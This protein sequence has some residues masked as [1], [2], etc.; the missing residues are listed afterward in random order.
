MRKKILIACSILVL[1]ISAISIL[2]RAYDLSSDF[3]YASAKLDIKN[4]NAKV[5]HVG[6]HEVS[7][8]EKEIEMIAARYGFKNIYVE[9][10]TPKQTEN[11]IKNYNELIDTYL[12]FRN[13]P[14]WKD[15]YK[16]EIDSVLTHPGL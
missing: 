12:A 5:I 7:A 16:K 9:K 3:N 8:K 1:L 15:R 10:F 6:V 11:G 4:G 2:W 14:G 13:G